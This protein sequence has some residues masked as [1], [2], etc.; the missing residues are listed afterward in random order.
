MLKIILIFTLLALSACCSSKQL[1]FNNEEEMQLWIINHPK[2]NIE[3][4]YQKSLMVQLG[5]KKDK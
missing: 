4:V 2:A 1:F 5:C 3:Y